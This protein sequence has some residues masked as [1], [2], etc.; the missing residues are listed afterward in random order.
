MSFSSLAAVFWM[1]ALGRAWGIRRSSELHFLLTRTNP[2]S[3][4]I[5]FP[6]QCTLASSKHP[7]RRKEPWGQIKCVQQSLAASLC[8]TPPCIIQ[9]S[10][11][12]C[13]SHQQIIFQ[14]YKQSTLQL[15]KSL[16]TSHKH[17]ANF[18]N[19]STPG[20]L[21]LHPSQL[22]LCGWMEFLGASSTN[23]AVWEITSTPPPKT[24]ASNKEHDQHCQ[25]LH[26]EGT[27]TL[28]IHGNTLSAIVSQMQRKEYFWHLSFVSA[29]LVQKE[30]GTKAI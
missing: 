19:P 3:V 25:N 4:L 1:G 23:E 6:Y 2:T 21:F 12:T 27:Q 24:Y 26:V 30:L 5:I 9:R 28:E 29:T 14:S 11:Q 13:R 17:L 18:T 8:S 16:S 15:S 7:H 20:D 10:E 22:C